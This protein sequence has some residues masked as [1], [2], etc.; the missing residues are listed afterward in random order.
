MINTGGPQHT[1][2]S[3][4]SGALVFA[5]GSGITY[6]L[7]VVQDLIQKDVEGR[8]RLKCV[9]LVWSVQDPGTRLSPPVFPSRLPLPF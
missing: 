3:S 7:G 8:S 5:G 6:A 1:L 4:F 9:E 2:Y